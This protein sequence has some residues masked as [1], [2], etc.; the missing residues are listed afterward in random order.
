MLNINDIKE[1]LTIENLMRHR[2]WPILLSI[3]LI[4]FS[5]R[6][7]TRHE[8][9]FDPD[10]YWWYQLAMYFAGIR[11]EHFIHE[12]GRTIY[13]LAHY[14]IGRAMENELLLLPFTIGFSYKL[15]GTFGALQTPDGILNYMFFLG[16]FFGALT[17]VSVYFLGRELTNSSKAGFIAATFYSFAHF[18]MTRNTAGDTGQES[19]GSLLLFGMLYFFILAIKQTNVKR[20]VGYASASGILF[21]LAANTWGGIHFYW[22]L[23]ASSV[24]AY[25]LINVFTDQP[26]ER[27]KSICVTFPVFIF[28][29]VLIPLLSHVGSLRIVGT[30]GADNTFQNL[31]YIT[32]LACLVPLGHN[33]LEKRKKAAF[34]PRVL[35]FST[36]AAIILVLL[37]TGKFTIVESIYDFIHRIVFTPEEKDLTGKTVAYYR[38]VG[39]SEFKGTFGPLLLAIPAG[40]LLVGHD[41]YKKKDFNSLFMIFLMLLGILSFRWMVRLSYFLAFILPLYVGYLFARYMRRDIERKQT[42]FRKKKKKRKG[43]ETQNTSRFHWIAAFSVLLFLIVPNLVSSIDSLK[44]QKFADTS[45]TPWKDAGEWIKENTP[46]NALLIHWWD[47]GYHLQTFAQRRTIVDGGNNGP[48]VEGGHPNN[49]NVDVASAFTSPEEEFYKYI[50]PYNPENLPIYVL[51]SYPEFGK[52]SAIN[53]HVNDELFISSFNVPNTGNQQQDQ[54]TIADM[55]QRNQINTY[56]IV[57][58]GNHYLVWALM[59]MDREG[60]Y[61]PEWSEKVLAKLLPFNTGYGQGMKHFQLVYQNGYVYVYKFVV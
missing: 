57:N 16:P 37:A 7:I 13:E 24:F 56:Y 36:F 8:L 10:S 15:L 50:E 46:E 27:Y 49:R 35:F 48:S 34:Q 42:S 32:A 33:E 53:F 31:S 23:L 21:F 17:A 22:G 40:F 14:P 38:S 5:T 39:F 52:S 30:I 4:G 59:E 2:T 26:L 44:G 25:L 45:V 43:V 61:H 19:L 54:K 29:V 1:K 9:L 47:Y 3:F 11:T 12:G 20:Q 28:V 55:L 41:F 51:V 6:Y 60:N 18:A 58:Y